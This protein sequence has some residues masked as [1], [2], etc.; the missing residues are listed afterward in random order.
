MQNVFAKMVPKLLNNGIKDQHLQVC[1]GILQ[2]LET[3]EYW[4][5]RVIT[6]SVS[7]ILEYNPRIKYQSFQWKSS[8]SPRPNRARQIKFKVTLITFF[9]VKGLSTKTSRHRVRR[10]FAHCLKKGEN[11][12][13][14][15]HWCFTVTTCLRHCHWN[16][17]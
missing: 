3:E 8:S 11:R 9:N 12:V 13:W 7:W 16:R 4:L 17:F 15:R 2:P 5:G 1:Q 14:T 10:C 6:S